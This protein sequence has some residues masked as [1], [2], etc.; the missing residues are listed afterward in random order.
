MFFKEESNKIEQLAAKIHIRKFFYADIIKR[1]EE[2]AATIVENMTSH[3]LH[4]FIINMSGNVGIG[5]TVTT[6]LNI[7]KN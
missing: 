4:T 1:K 5:T 7:V 6:A 3:D 2:A